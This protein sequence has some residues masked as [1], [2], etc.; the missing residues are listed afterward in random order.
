MLNYVVAGSIH[1]NNINIRF[2]LCKMEFQAIH[3]S[4]Y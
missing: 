2:E 1:T 3:I 4:N